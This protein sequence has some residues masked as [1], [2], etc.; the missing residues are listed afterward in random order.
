MD[1]LKTAVVDI[2][3]LVST[4]HAL[5]SFPSEGEEVLQRKPRNRLRRDLKRGT[6]A[7]I[8]TL[9]RTRRG[10]VDDDLLRRCRVA[11]EQQMPHALSH[12]ELLGRVMACEVGSLD[13]LAAARQ[14]LW[15]LA[16]VAICLSSGMSTLRGSSVLVHA[17][18]AD[19][20]AGRLRRR[21]R[22]ALIAY[23]RAALRNKASKG[24]LVVKAREA[25]LDEIGSR[26]AI[27]AERLADV[28][29]GADA[30]LGVI[31]QGVT[32]PLLDLALD[33]HLHRS[34]TNQR[35][36]PMPE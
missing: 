25:A 4:C 27:E 36:S 35:S 22:K 11:A 28:E 23:A 34:S 16:H 26:G 5:E 8:D 33:W 32:K 2:I 30:A 20:L 7:Y 21:L 15:R 18:S 29:A 3:T 31:R 13:G 19:A 12:E 24:R 14:D 9:A 17:R 6:V 10:V 1:L